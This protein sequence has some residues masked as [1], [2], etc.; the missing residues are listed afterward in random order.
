MPKRSRISLDQ[1]APAHIVEWE[2]TVRYRVCGRFLLLALLVAGFLWLRTPASGKSARG[3]AAPPPVEVKYF[4]T[5]SCSSMACHHFN[6][7]EGSERSEYSTWANGDKHSRAYTVL[8]DDRS[9][10]IIKNLRGPKAPA[11]TKDRLCLKCHATNDGNSRDASEQFVLADGVGCEA[12]HGP[13]QKYLTEHYVAGFKEKPAEEKE[14]VYGLKNTKSLVK[15]AEMC[16]TCHVGDGNREVNHDLIAAGH[17]RLNFELAGYH[18]IYHKH[19]SDAAEKA[20]DPDF[21]AR[22]WLIGQLV[23]TKSAIDLLAARAKGAE[24][25]VDKGGKPWPEFA[26]YACFA[27]HKDLQV[28]SPRQRVGY[29]DRHPGAFPYGTWYL[30]GLEPLAD[31]LSR[32]PDDLKFAALRKS[33]ERPGPSS[34]EVAAEAEKSSALLAK[35]LSDVEK[36]KPLDLPR[37]RGFM[38]ACVADGLKKTGRQVIV[39]EATSTTPAKT[40]EGAQIDEMTWDRAAQLYLSLAAFSEAL[41]DAGA[42][43]PTLIRN[44]LLA[45]KSRL[46]GAF[47][48]G[49]DSPQNYDPLEKPAKGIRS[50]KE[51]L[52][53]IRVQLGQ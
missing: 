25:D 42:R 21:Y 24:L 7:P 19:W 28:N 20:R 41:S 6:G 52:E 44:D 50:L 1:P 39:E 40:R 14:R 10:R 36:S 30:A 49:S 51:H 53:A 2:S 38:A 35:L 26:E 32:N 17:P 16:I 11:A 48:K 3:D 47:P 45:M 18:G 46:K 22:I 37:I 15:R 9:E 34:R 43:Q 31:Q 8:Y 29:G 23:T 4:G 13:A 27:C 33:M 12:C 5:A